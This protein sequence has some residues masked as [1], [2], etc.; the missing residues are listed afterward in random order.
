VFVALVFGTQVDGSATFRLSLPR[1][2]SEA[3]RKS[4]RDRN[5]R[6]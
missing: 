4:L 5:W 2:S 3:W 6:P 1:G